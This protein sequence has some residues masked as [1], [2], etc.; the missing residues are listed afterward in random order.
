MIARFGLAGVFLAL[1]LTATGEDT[2]SLVP[3][4]VQ[5]QRLEGA[6]SVSPETR[7][8][9]GDNADTL[10]PVARHL[11][12][13]IKEQTGYALTVQPGGESQGGVLLS[14]AAADAALGDEGYALAVGP[15]SVVIRAA[16]PAGVF[17]GVQTLRQLLVREEAGS[18]AAK[19]ARTIPCVQIE[20]RPRFAWRGMHLDVARHF[21]D[22]QFVKRYIDHISACKLNI[23]H[24]YLTDD[25]GWRIQ[26]RRYPRLTEIGA[27]RSGTQKHY[28]DGRGDLARYG[29]YFTQDDLRE[30]VAYAHERFVTV[31]PGISMPGHSQAALAAYPELSSTGGPFE[32]WTD[33]G[34]SKEVMDPGKEEVFEFVENVLSEV[35]DVFP[36]RWIHTGGDEVPR[37]RWKASP[38]AQAR[39]RQEGLKDEDGLQSYFT[40]RVERF[41]NSKGRALIGWDEI[42]EGGLA[43]NAVVMS[44]RGTKG[45]IEA[46]RAGHHVVMTP[47]Q[48]TYFNYMQHKDRRGPGHAAHLPLLAVYHFDPTRGLSPEE[49]KYVLG[50][51]ACLWTEYVPAPADVEYLLFPRLLAMAEVLW[52]PLEGRSD[53]EFVR[54]VPAQLEKLKETGTGYCPD[55]RE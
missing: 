3:K 2:V 13:A 17:Y 21:F 27:W 54:R 30:I 55:W 53:S 7:I 36:S 8:I 5:C 31:V 47:N 24:L 44:W 49:A 40:K 14:C 33:W 45:G 26:I 35:I 43:P 23:F 32:V 50:G 6:F 41:L 22:K 52:S 37:D 16:R 1:P 4:P 39:I 48:E 9:V 25:Q 42:L 29:G 15:N 28:S 34:I 11:A 46:A 12:Q 51:Q 18:A 38:Y 10:L 20:D 19:P